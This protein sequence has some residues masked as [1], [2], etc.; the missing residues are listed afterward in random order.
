MYIMEKDYNI[1]CI[2]KQNNEAT[3]PDVT[4]GKCVR[5]D[6]GEMALDDEA[7]KVEWQVNYLKLLN[8]EFLWDSERLSA[9]DPLLRPHIHITLKMVK[10]AVKIS[11]SGKAA[12]LLDIVAEMLKFSGNNYISYLTQLLNTIVIEGCIPTDWDTSYVVNYYK[13]KATHSRG[14]TTGD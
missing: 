6:R 11:K 2:A 4:G 3:E 1:F 7:N 8:V 13:G 10:D 14:E 5:N 9:V 12:G